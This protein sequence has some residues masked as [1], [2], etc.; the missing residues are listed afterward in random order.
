M[1][2][3]TL[4][5]LPP[6]A[7]IPAAGPRAP[8]LSE[9]DYLT[10]LQR[11]LPQGRAWSRSPD[12]KLTGLLRGI[13]KRQ[14]ALQQRQVNLLSDAFPS[15]PVELLPEWEASLGLPD[16]CAGILP[17]VAQRQAQVRAR[18]AAAGGQSIDY[19]IGVAAALGVTI[20]IDELSD[21]DCDDPVDEDLNGYMPAGF[22]DVWECGRSG[23]DDYL[24]VWDWHQP[25]SDYDFALLITVTQEP[26]FIWSCDDGCDENLTDFSQTPAA[27]YEEWAVGDSDCEDPLAVFGDAVLECELLRIL[28]AHVTPIFAYA[29]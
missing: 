13:A 28:P 7:A 1:P 22:A 3:L 14:A 17:T 10:G 4:W 2:L 23:C 15:E 18:W 16:P 26:D 24:T 25:A 8:L 5:P 20:T 29:A 6:V 11:L 21:W 27:T 9:D 19:F 12:S